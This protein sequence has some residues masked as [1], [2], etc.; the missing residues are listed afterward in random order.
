LTGLSRPK[1]ERQQLS[2]P[3][4]AL[5]F[6]KIGII[7]FGGGMAIIALMEHELVRKQRVIEPDEFLHGVGLSQILGPFAVNTALFTGYRRY[8]ILGGLIAACA[9]MAPS[10]VIA[11]AGTAAILP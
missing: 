7:G 4:V 6:L 11:A 8:G 5:V 9:F 2:L 10:L 1:P 3:A